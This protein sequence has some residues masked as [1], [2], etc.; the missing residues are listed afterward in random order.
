MNAI[1][2]MLRYE[3]QHDCKKLK[4]RKGA[5]S[6]IHQ[7]ARMTAQSVSDAHPASSICTA[8]QREPPSRCG[9]DGRWHP[10]D[11]LDHMQEIMQAGDQSETAT[12]GAI[13][14]V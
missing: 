13:I 7:G 1:D 9:G 6:T 11:L 3:T 10:S 5:R 12:H 4:T 14:V 2:F 8:H